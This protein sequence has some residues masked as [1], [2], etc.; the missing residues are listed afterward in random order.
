MRSWKFEMS[1]VF[2]SLAAFAAV[3][4]LSLS[5]SEAGPIRFRGRGADQGS[6][7]R[8]AFAGGTFGVHSRRIREGSFGARQTAFWLDGVRQALDAAR[9][10]QGL[11]RNKHQSTGI[12]LPPILRPHLD[13]PWDE[14]P[15][16]PMD[17]QLDRELDGQPT[18][19]P[20]ADPD[21]DPAQSPPGPGIDEDIDFTPNPEPATLLLFGAGAAAGAAYRRRRRRREAR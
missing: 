18:P 12:Y 21:P 13:T 1:L 5:T 6:A 4:F 10:S 3:A 7:G 11:L 20:F 8:F 19:E 15:D 2:R 14:Q 16:E 9:V 17:E